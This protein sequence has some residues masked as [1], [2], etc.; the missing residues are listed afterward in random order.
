MLALVMLALILIVTPASAKLVSPYGDKNATSIEMFIIQTGNTTFTATLTLYQITQ[1]FGSDNSQSPNYVGALPSGLQISGTNSPGSGSMEGKIVAPGTMAFPLQGKA[2]NLKSGGS[3]QTNTTDSNG[4]TTFTFDIDKMSL[5]N[6]CIEIYGEFLGDN[7]LLA[8]QGRRQKICQNSLIPLDVPLTKVIETISKNPGFQNTCIY[9]FVVIGFLMAGLY[10]S[11]KDPLKLLDITTPRLPSARRKPEIKISISEDK[12]KVLRKQQYEHERELEN[13]IKGTAR[14]IAKSSDSVRSA[15]NDTARKKEEERIYREIMER[16]EDKKREALKKISD[17]VK[18]IA[19]N[20]AIVID[21]NQT[22]GMY[23]NIGAELV[24]AANKG[25]IASDKNAAAIRARQKIKDMWEMQ[26]S[27]NSRRE[28][29]GI[30][31]ANKYVSERLVSDFASLVDR[32]VVGVGGT[33]GKVKAVLPESYHKTIDEI[34]KGRSGREGL[35]S[36]TGTISPLRRRAESITGVGYAVRVADDL[37]GWVKMSV[38]TPLRAAEYARSGMKY[39]SSKGEVDKLQ[40]NYFKEYKDFEQ[41]QADARMLGYAVPIAT[42]KAHNKKL[43]DIQAEIDFAEIK[44][45][46]AKEK[47]ALAKESGT[48][49]PDLIKPAQEAVIATT[50]L[51]KEL[52]NDINNRLLKEFIEKSKEGITGTSALKKIDEEMDKWRGE[53]IGETRE[54][55]ERHE[56]IKDKF[57]DNGWGQLYRDTMEKKEEG[58]FVEVQKYD[59]YTREGFYKVLTPSDGKYTSK[60]YALNEVYGIATD[61]LTS[62]S[63]PEEAAFI[64][65]AGRAIGQDPLKYDAIIETQQ[66][67]LRRYLEL[68]DF[69]REDVLIKAKNEGLDAAVRMMSNVEKFETPEKI[70]ETHARYVGDDELFSLIGATNRPERYKRRVEDI[71]REEMGFLAFSEAFHYMIGSFEKEAHNMTKKKAV[72]DT[73]MGNDFE[74]VRRHYSRQM[75]DL[76]MRI[77]EMGQIEGHEMPDLER[78]YRL[79]QIRQ[80]TLNSLRDIYHLKMDEA[81]YTNFSNRMGTAMETHEAQANS[82]ENL[83]KLSN[84]STLVEKAVIEWSATAALNRATGVMGRVGLKENIGDLANTAEWENTCIKVTEDHGRVLNKD[85]KNRMVKINE[86]MGFIIEKGK[87]QNM[88]A[89]DLLLEMDKKWKGVMFPAMMDFFKDVSKE[90]EAYYDLFVEDKINGKEHIFVKAFEVPVTRDSAGNVDYGRVSYEETQNLIVIANK[91]LPNRKNDLAAKVIARA[92]GKGITITADQAKKYIEFYDLLGSNAIMHVGAYLPGEALAKVPWIVESKGE[93]LACPKYMPKYETMGS[94]DTMVNAG[95]AIDEKGRTIVSPIEETLT[96]RVNTWLA[97]RSN[98]FLHGSYIGIMA[99]AKTTTVTFTRHGGYLKKHVLGAFRG[100]TEFT[101]D[102]TRNEQLANKLVEAYKLKYLMSREAEID[103]EEFNK[104]LKIMLKPEKIKENLK[105]ELIN[106]K[107]KME[108]D[109]AGR[110][111]KLSDINN[112]R[113]IPGIKAE[114][115][116]IDRMLKSPTISPEDYDRQGKKMEILG[117]YLKVLDAINVVETAGDLRYR[118]PKKPDELIEL[119]KVID[120]CKNLVGEF[121]MQENLLDLMSKSRL[122]KEEGQHELDYARKEIGFIENVS[123]STFVKQLKGELKGLTLPP[124]AEKEIDDLLKDIKSKIEAS[125]DPAKETKKDLTLVDTAVDELIGKLDRAK[126]R[127]QAALPSMENLIIDKAALEAKYGPQISAIANAADCGRVAATILAD[128]EIS[129]ALTASQDV[130]YRASKMRGIEAKITSAKS[131]AELERAFNSMFESVFVDAGVYKEAG[132]T[133]NAAG[134]EM[135]YAG[136]IRSAAT[137]A[138]FRTLADEILADSEVR[139]ALSSLPPGALEIITKRL[140]SSENAIEFAQAFHHLLNGSYGVGALHRNNEEISHK[141]KSLRIGMKAKVK[142]Y[143][144]RYD[145]MHGLEDKLSA[146]MKVDE[147]LEPINME[148]AKYKRFW[149]LTLSEISRD[150]SLKLMRFGNFQMAKWKGKTSARAKTPFSIVDEIKLYSEAVKTK[151]KERTEFENLMIAHLRNSA[152]ISEKFLMRAYTLYST[153]AAQAHTR[154]KGYGLNF[155]GQAGYQFAGPLPSTLMQQLVTYGR[156]GNAGWFT[157]MMLAHPIRKVQRT[158]AQRYSVTRL[159][160]GV[161]AVY[162]PM[163]GTGGFFGDKMNSVKAMMYMKFKDR[164][165]KFGEVIRTTAKD[166]SPPVFAPYLLSRNPY[167]EMRISELLEMFTDDFRATARGPRDCLNY[168]LYKPNDIVIDFQDILFSMKESRSMKKTPEHLMDVGIYGVV[169]NSGFIAGREI[170]FIE[171]AL[172]GPESMYPNRGWGIMHYN[173]QLSTPAMRYSGYADFYKRTMKPTEVA[174]E[175][176]RMTEFAEETRWQPLV[177]AIAMYFMPMLTAPALL[178]LFGLGSAY[179][180]RNHMKY[181]AIRAK[182]YISR[183]PWRGDSWKTYET[184]SERLR[185]MYMGMY[186]TGGT[187]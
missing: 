69:V 122:R 107:E 5:D 10:A 55:V 86:S 68:D 140:R 134:V 79:G 163:K 15:P 96:R 136:K 148:R 138:N 179:K 44:L 103:K 47:W 65:G 187:P 41:I 7:T 151:A 170:N 93:Y 177:P 186:G 53:L 83:V 147:L 26:G 132:F 149:N 88:E 11:G 184:L 63:D 183:P 141:I 126:Q 174:T 95:F 48:L 80:R 111:L 159:M 166:R 52:I 9:F 33:V 27:G 116:T 23:A 32:G 146:G 115:T 143:L 37:R 12:M 173:P 56:K 182:N 102:V 36:E 91:E 164:L 121:V 39:R 67:Q 50:N 82:Q 3:S 30:M 66:Q 71:T 1:S 81:T 89:E 128:P 100:N 127:V 105:T 150:L 58:L 2:I 8:S 59:E 98:N 139:S 178:G 64:I 38:E 172:G 94:A 112:I 171:T 158:Y 42:Q 85:K 142:D 97:A 25:I 74:N 119:D 114:I 124:D 75:S 145:G 46:E 118:N 87:A 130:T 62:I 73:N 165:A 144:Q 16:V 61:N 99:E 175:I 18:G 20:R 110:E 54:V 60:R 131:K 22:Y 14:S 156:H 152:F 104:I 90:S 162:E 154:M 84:D 123:K 168:L 161:P 176:V 137:P 106:I 153:F 109:L 113:G 24:N 31:L 135:R 21:Y 185:N 13:S 40:Q 43:T 45:D 57:Y 169:A 125:K 133:I 157:S 160:T 70:R 72:R 6:G 108:T 120:T 28:S 129:A 51:S 155:S 77:R 17:S 49:K 167:G 78:E 35:F 101:K 19:I 92:A 76:Q 34:A 117:E 4:Q 181:S 180:Y 29:P